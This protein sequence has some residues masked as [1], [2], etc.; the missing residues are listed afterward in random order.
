MEGLSRWRRVNT[1]Y[2]SS[3]NHRV[4]LKRRTRK[5]RN[6]C[7][8]FNI[9]LSVIT[10]FTLII[11]CHTLEIKRTLLL[12]SLVCLILV[13]NV[14]CQDAKSGENFLQS[15]ADQS[16]NKSFFITVTP[17]IQETERSFMVVSSCGQNKSILVRSL[18][19]LTSKTKI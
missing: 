1:R 17:E 14:C 13:S 18:L 16:V 6:D 4:L 2:E 7:Q 12:P 15:Q 8:A 19:F 10:T 9:T 3:E 11:M 5:E